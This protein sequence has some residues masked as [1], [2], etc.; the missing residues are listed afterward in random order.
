MDCKLR[1]INVRSV[2]DTMR[3]LRPVFGVTE[4]CGY[5]YMSTVGVVV[6][7]FGTPRSPGENFWCMSEILGALGRCQ[8]ELATTLGAP[9][10]CIGA[11]VTRL[12]APVTSL[13]APVPNLGALVTSQ[14][15]PA[16]SLK[17]R[18]NSLGAPA[19]TLGPP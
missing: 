10:T 4:T 11:P 5:L 19:P 15:A 14:G 18:M 1:C 16:P 6:M 9:A 7:S 12:G 17:S 13:G 3:A 8:G 2:S